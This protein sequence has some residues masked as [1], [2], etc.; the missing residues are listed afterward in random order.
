MRTIA[1]IQARL[2]S[3]RL[4]GKVLYPAPDGRPLLAVMLERVK[5]ARRVDQVGL[6]IP[7]GGLDDR[8]LGKWASPRDGDFGMIVTGS[9]DDVLSRFWV[10]VEGLADTDVIVRLTGDCPLVD[11]ELIDWCAWHVQSGN[12]AYCRT[13]ESVPEGLDVEAFTKRALGLAWA[14]ATLPSE[15]EHVTPWMKTHLAN[16]GVYELPED[17]GH[18]R[19][20]VDE[21][22]DYGV[23]WEVLR[24]L[25]PDCRLV[26]ILALQKRAPR[27]FERNAHLERNPW[28][29]QW[30]A[31]RVTV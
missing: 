4:P 19:L 1:L 13:G 23:V 16:Q 28:K 30:E 20:T 10:G 14:G 26:D 2:S 31:E 24:E 6:A 8:L 3:T 15:R 5:K 22:E 11:P 21:H 7:S 12:Y 18:L 29:K 9:A 27:I 25:G 17:C